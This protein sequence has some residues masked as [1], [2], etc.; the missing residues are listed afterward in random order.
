MSF[1]RFAENYAGQAEFQRQIAGQLVQGLTATG[2][3]LDLGSGTGF[4]GQALRQ[5]HPSLEWIEVDRSPAML[6]QSS[7]P[8]RMCADGLRLPFAS[9]A[10]DWAVSSLALQW[11][12]SAQEML[13]VLKPGAFY[14]VVLVLP[15]SLS[16][17]TRALD[18]IGRRHET[19]GQG[20]PEQWALDL[21]GQQRIE[22]RICEFPSP[23]AAL[24]S[25]RDIGAGGQSGAAMSRSEYRQFLA[26]LGSRL[27]YQLLWIEG[28]CPCES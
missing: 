24:A 2:L 25:V 16:E 4:V 18:A 12:G 6:Q 28:H 15:G 17:L 13:R 26:A 1:N 10:F 11:I 23:R 9:N 22:T 3:G 8:N 27:T 20:T 5:Q 21:P 7:H 14:R 19:L